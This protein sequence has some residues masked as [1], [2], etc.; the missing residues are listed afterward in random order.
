[1]DHCCCKKAR[2]KSLPVLGL[3]L[4]VIEGMMMLPARLDLLSD[5]CVSPL[6]HVL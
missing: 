3:Y 6:Y 5:F 2:A 4:P 1:M